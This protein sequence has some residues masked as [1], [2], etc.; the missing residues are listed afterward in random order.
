MIYIILIWIPNISASYFETSTCCRSICRTIVLQL[1]VRVSLLRIC[2]CFMPC[3]ETVSA[4]HFPFGSFY[5]SLSLFVS[6]V[7][8]PPCKSSTNDWINNEK[9]CRG[10]HRIDRV[11]R[12]FWIKLKV[13]GS[14]VRVSGC[15]VSKWAREGSK[16][17]N[18]RGR[19]AKKQ[20]RG[21]IVRGKVRDGRFQRQ[22]L[23]VIGSLH[24]NSSLSLSHNIYLF[25]A[26]LPIYD[27]VS[28][29]K[30]NLSAVRHILH[31]H[32]IQICNCLHNH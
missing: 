29:I 17:R 13:F 1:S 24:S 19:E 2:I 30:F 28:S 6:H 32:T 15:R 5:F 22:R 25:S 11:H 12:I 16:L 8:F 31:V 4:Q 20:R 18:V 3:I 27:S 7:I 9:S 21:E 23:W 14:S 26:S 10:Y